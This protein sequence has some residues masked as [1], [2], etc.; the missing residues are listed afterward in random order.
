MNKLWLDFE[1][2]SE[3]DITK[4]GLYWHLE[5]P[6][7]RPLIVTYAFDDGPVQIFEFESG[8]F[9]SDL[10]AALAN[11]DVLL[12][13]ANT[14]FDRGILKYQLGIEVPWER[15]RDL[16]TLAYSMSFNGSLEAIGEQI[17]LSEDK[18]KIKDG[19]RL[20]RKFC[21]PQP[22]NRKIKHWD[23]NNDPDDWQA[24]R[25]YALQDVETM[26]TIWNLLE[27]YG[28]TNDN[29]WRE[30]AYTQ[31]MNERGVPVDMELVDRAIELSEIR[32]EEILKELAH[33]TGLDNPN[34]PTQMKNWLGRHGFDMPNMQAA[35]L[36]RAIESA[37]DVFIK[38]VLSLYK[39]VGQTSIKKWH[40]V[41]DMVSRDGT[42]KGMYTFIG[43]SRTGRYA[44]RGIN[45][46]NLKRPPKGNMDELVE[47]IR[48]GNLEAIKWVFGEPMDFLSKCI[49]GA[50]T[51]PEGQKLVVSDLVSIESVLLG[52]LTNCRRISNIFA[53]GKDTY[54]DFATELFGVIYEAVTKDQR[55]F[56]KPAVLGCGYFMGA[57][58]LKAYAEGMGIDMT[59]EDAKHAV[60]VFREAY[61]E[62]PEFWWWLRDTIEQV[63][64]TGQPAEGY[65]LS[66]QIENGPVGQFLSITLPSGRKIWYHKPQLRPTII[67]KGTEDEFE[68]V[69]F[70]YMGIN[71]FKGVKWERIDVHVG[72]VTEN[73]VQSMARDIML[74]WLL[75]LEAYPVVGTT[76]DELILPDGNPEATLE[77]V[78]KTIQDPMPWAPDLKL[79]ADG[80]ITKHYTKD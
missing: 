20:I 72:G 9:P 57:K 49:R 50:I 16:F 61:P 45:I 15:C 19:K 24:F 48:R 14:P 65:R 33:V 56:S 8:G 12:V 59:L 80:F 23:K 32:K 30:Y 76:H 2:Y 71:R 60:K 25:E 37:G 29:T 68:T 1:T 7:T 63:V 22:A 10:G 4:R 74:E 31:R 64:R 53:A 42:I 27:P 3:C 28:S 46:Q 36:D 78:N 18:A 75:R 77:I 58:G 69:S 54:K 35:T 17:G 70:S 73:I 11:P 13:A 66:F 62:I 40:K 39:A 6:T 51:A 21:M 41:A 44:S 34:S 47:Y 38:H 43:A 5:D 67:N 79:N 52:W 55:T 26:R